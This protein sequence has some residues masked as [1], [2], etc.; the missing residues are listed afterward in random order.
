MGKAAQSSPLEA[1][2]VAQNPKINA[3]IRVKLNAWQAL[4]HRRYHALDP[5]TAPLN[6]LEA[7]RYALAACVASQDLEHFWDL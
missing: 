1:A 3:Y 5:T 4:G 2:R 7:V 6:F